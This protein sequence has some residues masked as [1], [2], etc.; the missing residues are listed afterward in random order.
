MVIIAKDD[1]WIL[2]KLIVGLYTQD[3]IR[4]HKYYFPH[5]N[6]IDYNKLIEGVIS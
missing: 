6:T 2:K 1:G 4:I 3:G 5:T